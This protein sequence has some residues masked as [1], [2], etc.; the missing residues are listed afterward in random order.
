MLLTAEPA[1]DIRTAPP[2]DVTGEGGASV[3]N[4]KA[5][6]PTV[7]DS[8]RMQTKR[9]LEEMADTPDF[10]EACKQYARD[11]ESLFPFDELKKK[12][13]SKRHKDRLVRVPM[14]LRNAQQTLALTCPYRHDGAWEPCDRVPPP[15]AK[16]DDDQTDP[17]QTAFAQTL[18]MEVRDEYVSS[19][20]T[21]TIR[22]YVSHAIWFRVG[23]VK[24]TYQREFLTDPITAARAN[25][26]SDNMARL[27]DLTMR[28][29]RG[30]ITE[31]DAEWQDKLDLEEQILA[32]GELRRWEGVRAE[33]VP[34]TRFRMD[35]SVKSLARALDAGWHDFEY[36]YRRSFVRTRFPYAPG[37]DGV[38]WTG[39]HPDDLEKATTCDEFGQ[40]DAKAS[41]DGP[42]QKASRKTEADKDNDPWV[43]IH[44]RWNLT[45]GTVYWL[46]DGVDYPLDTWIPDRQPGR[47]YPTHLLVLNDDPM[48]WY[49]RS[50]TELQAPVQDRWNR[51]ASDEELARWFS[52]ARIFCTDNVD[53]PEDIEFPDPGKIKVIPAAQ[54]KP[55]ND[56]L[57]VVTMPL[58]QASFDRSDDERQMRS[59]ARVPEQALG[60]TDGRTTATAIQAASQGSA[61]A[62]S[63]K[64]EVVKQALHEIR[65]HVAEILLQERK[66]D[67]VMARRGP[68]AIWPKVYA[69]AD[70]KR[71]KTQIQQQVQQKITDDLMAIET[72]AA[73][74]GQR[75]PEPD[76]VAVDRQ[77][78]ALTE[79]A[80]ISKTGMPF[81]MSREELYRGLRLSIDVNTDGQADAMARFDRVIQMVQALGQSGVM[82]D[83]D[84][85]SRLV[86]Q[87]MREDKAASKLF[88][89]RPDDLAARLVQAVQGGKKLSPEAM[90]AL[91]ALIAPAP[92]PGAPPAPG[93]P[94]VEQAQPAA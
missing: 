39:V 35:P 25:D 78:A 64:Q 9:M 47:W 56:V 62:T 59:L 55:I 69:E 38:T 90:Q 18:T 80:C 89:T 52:I 42:G 68:H 87:I 67:E 79:Q 43:K 88:V 76:V 53:K 13:R 32:G 5:A 40:V 84:A 49:G 66:A 20:L 94:P 14:V 26:L 22:E 31:Q 45:T 41:R 82:P 1:T 10:T 2:V 60:V 16:P 11:V 48:S 29:A 6:P 34:L 57:Q 30:E 44:E 28:A 70:A 51:K 46:V 4:A 27:Q 91:M 75:A 74:V 71:I 37:A 58:N 77:I 3:P 19:R 12:G 92:P 7:P 23:I 24:L 81:V 17:I 8:V 65:Q 83:P 36:I 50:D 85:L 63:D 86:G 72:Q 33:V 15:G 73:M 54:G 93:A 61:V 21:P